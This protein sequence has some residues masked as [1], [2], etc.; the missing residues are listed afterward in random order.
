[1][2]CYDTTPVAYQGNQDITFAGNTVTGFP[3]MPALTL[4][5]GENITVRGNV[6]QRFDSTTTSTC[7]NDTIV[8]QAISL[9]NDDGVTIKN[10]T[11]AS[12]NLLGPS[13]MLVDTATCIGVTING[14]AVGTQ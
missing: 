11:D 3:C 1:V 6:L 2:N 7:L 5:C 14:K 8:P 10:N 13:D 9:L 12:G 4:A